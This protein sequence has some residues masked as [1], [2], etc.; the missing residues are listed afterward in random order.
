M[1]FL[2]E[3]VPELPG[4][5]CILLNLGDLD[6]HPVVKPRQEVTANDQTVFRCPHSMDPTR[7]DQHG[8]ALAEVNP[9]AFLGLITQEGTIL[10]RRVTPFLVFL[11]MLVFGWYEK[12]GLLPLEDVVVDR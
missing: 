2:E 11:E 6:L 1:D 4:N 7:R 8:V 10:R 12:E 5:F 3:W 9:I